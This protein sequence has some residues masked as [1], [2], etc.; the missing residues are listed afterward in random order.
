MIATI[1]APFVVTPPVGAEI[2]MFFFFVRHQYSVCLAELMT[3]RWCNC[4]VC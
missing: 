1:S 3:V 4:S 2:Y